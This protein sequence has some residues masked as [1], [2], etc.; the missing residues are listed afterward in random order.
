MGASN[1]ALAATLWCPRL[2]SNNAARVALLVMANVAL[3]NDSTKDGKVTR[4]RRLYFAGYPLI[5][6]ALGL[7][8][9][10]ATQRQC[11][12]RHISTLVKVGAVSVAEKHAPGRNA[13]YQLNLDLGTVAPETQ[14]STDE[15][16][17]LSSE[18]SCVSDPGHLRHPSISLA[19]TTQLEEQEDLP[20]S[21]IED[22]FPSS[23]VSSPQ[24]EDTCPDCEGHGRVSVYEGGYLMDKRCTHPKLRRTA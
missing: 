10:E 17:R 1:V 24:S 8:G 9:D 19:S 6:D 22:N 14:V 15:H 23:G 3:D 5:A 12:S 18:G 2:G 4:R 11:V 20:R 7:K 21:E 16:L 13:K